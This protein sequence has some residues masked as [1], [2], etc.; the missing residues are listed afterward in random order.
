MRL[1]QGRNRPAPRAVHG[2]WRAARALWSGAVVALVLLPAAA[3]VAQPAPAVSGELKRW[4]KVSVTLDGPATSATAS[5]NPFLDLRMDVT[6][7]HVASRTTYRVPGFFDADGDAANTSAN[8][9]STWRAILRPDQVGDWTYRISFRQGAGVAVA[10]SPT[11]GHPLAP[12]DD[13]TGAFSVADTDKTGRDFRAHGML[14]YVNR[15]HLQFAGTS[16][17]FLKV[18][19]DSPENLLAYEDFDDTPN[20]TW[21][22]RLGGGFRKRYKAHV[23]DW[24]SGDPTWKNGKGKGLIGALNYL[25]SKGLNSQSFLTYSIHGDDRNVSPYID[26]EDRTR[27][28]VAKLAQWEIV[29][30]HMERLGLFMEFKLMETENDWDHDAGELGPERRLYYRELIARF[31]HHLALYWNVGEENSNTP[32]Q[33][34]DFGEYIYATDPYKHLIVIHN[35]GSWE[36]LYRPLMGKNSPYKGASLQIDLY[37]VY[38][39]TRFLRLS[40]DAAGSPWV[41]FLDETRPGPAG[42]ALGHVNAAVARDVADPEHDEGRKGGLWAIIMAGGAGMNTYVGFGTDVGEKSTTGTSVDVPDLMLEDFRVYDK[43]WNQMRAAHE[44]FVA[45]K[46]PFHDMSNRSELVSTGWALE[47]KGMIVAYFPNGPVGGI[48]GR[49]DGAAFAPRFPGTQGGAG[50][51]AALDPSRTDSVRQSPG[52]RGGPGAVGPNPG[53][54]RHGQAPTAGPGT[55]LA[56]PSINL[57]EYQGSYEVRWYDPRKGGSLQVGTVATLTSGGRDWV[58]VGHPPSDPNRDWVLLVRAAAEARPTDSR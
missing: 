21:E 29:F 10:D 2:Q 49:A 48:R 45:N 39:V 19:S 13:Q 1:K 43:W 28:S 51:G 30:D 38:D 22:G 42:T 50:R 6:F 33:R 4:H 37:D 58:E 34:K 54:D 17:Y 15:H 11:A 3:A 56:T 44:F 8:S 35:V 16:E 32:A 27:L 57:G 14:K 36:R 55:P 26:S 23:R 52:A 20:Y 46:V 18:G 25:A 5:P 31:G 24:Q 53:G 9:G 47:G 40:S 12:Y 41:I 7:T